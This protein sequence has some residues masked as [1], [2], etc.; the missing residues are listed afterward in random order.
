MGTTLAC[1]WKLCLQVGSAFLQQT[2]RWLRWLSVSSM[3]QKEVN[4]FLRSKAARQPLAADCQARL[5]KTVRYV[6][7]GYKQINK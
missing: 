4:M 1:N 6:L 2:F 5:T 7:L 3:L